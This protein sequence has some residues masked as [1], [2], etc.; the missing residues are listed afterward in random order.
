MNLVSSLFSRIRKICSPQFLSDEIKNM[1]DILIRNGY[2]LWFIRKYSVDTIKPITAEKKKIF[3]SLPYYGHQSAQIGRSIVK[4][5]ES[6]F[7]SVRL[8]I[9]YKTNRLGP[10]A[11]KDVTP[12]PHQHNI[13]YKFLCGCGATYL[14]KTAR[15]L[16]VRIKEHT[17][18]WIFQGTTRPRS[19]KAPSSNI[20]RHLQECP[21]RSKCSVNNFSSVKKCISPYELFI[22]EGVAIKWLNPSLCIQKDRIYV[23]TIL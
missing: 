1:E 18:K 8:C 5:V 19:S 12:L 6:C 4:A 3:C 11:P 7:F 2:P 21:H 15:P 14:G 22:A 23:S 20:T 10:N 9:A 17:P 16:R 13:I